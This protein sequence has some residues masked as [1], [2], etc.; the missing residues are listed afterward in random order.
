MLQ[1]ER[2]MSLHQVI[3]VEAGAQTLCMTMQDF[4]RAGDAF[5]AK[6][7]PVFRGV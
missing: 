4:R 7:R 6:Q 1:M 3:E 2:A 5:V